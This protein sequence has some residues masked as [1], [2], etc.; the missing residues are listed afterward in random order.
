MYTG[1]IS[2]HATAVY[3]QQPTSQKSLSLSHEVRHAP[4]SVATISQS[5]T[6]LHSNTVLPME[7]AT[8]VMELET[9][10]SWS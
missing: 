5:I 7:A 1:D 3:I 6:K 8:Y 4:A 2:W 9:K 10:W